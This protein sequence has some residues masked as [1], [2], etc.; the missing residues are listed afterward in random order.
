[1]DHQ[2]KFMDMYIGW[3]GSVHDARVLVNSNVFT[4]AEAG[5]PLSATRC[6]FAI[7][8]LSH[9][10]GDRASSI[11]SLVELARIVTK[12]AFGHLKG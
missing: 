10:H 1:M 11:T 2:C 4:K 7:L 9:W 6:P 8:V 12:I 3:P 5:D